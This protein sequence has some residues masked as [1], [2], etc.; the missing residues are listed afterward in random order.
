M[1]CTSSQPWHINV[2][3]QVHII[4]GDSYS[5]HAPST[6]TYCS[7]YPIRQ[8]S[9]SLHSVHLLIL[10]KSGFSIPGNFMYHVQS[11][12]C[13]LHCQFSP[14]LE[15]TSVTFASCLFNSYHI[16][17]RP[18]SFSAVGALF[19]C[20]CAALLCLAYPRLASM[21]PS[22]HGLSGRHFISG[23]LSDWRAAYCLACLF[24][25]LLYMLQFL[26]LL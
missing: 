9:M 20:Q 21:V 7:W 18:A 6:F 17:L 15:Y 11:F 13:T 14:V 3:W 25:L 16:F 23:S 1:V 12:H 5:V 24:R 22:G 26:C 8:L 4:L 19:N 10:P 2:H